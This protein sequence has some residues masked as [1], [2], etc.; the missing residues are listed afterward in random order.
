MTKLFAHRTTAAALLVTLGVLLAACGQQ[1]SISAGT[2]VA[3]IAAGNTAA[4]NTAGGSTPV[5]GMATGNTATGNTTT[6]STAT[7][8]AAASGAPAE[9]VSSEATLIPALATAGALT[10]DAGSTPQAAFDLTALDPC[11]LL[12]EGDVKSAMGSVTYA[13]TPKPQ[14]QDAFHTACSYV[15]PGLEE[16]SP[17]LFLVVETTDTWEM[18]TSDVQ[19][20]SGIGDEAQTHNFNGWRSLWV[21]LKNRALVQ[22]DIYPPDLEKAKQLASKAIQRLP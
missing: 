19:T 9:G 10:G 21:L 13:F 6:S 11:K 16:N 18:H 8:D 4:G 17:R 14:Y 20:V 12:T 15:E 5:A 1:S 3:G 2:P 7:G 22:V